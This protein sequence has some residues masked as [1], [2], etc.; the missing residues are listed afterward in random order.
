M[1]RVVKEEPGRGARHY[2][3]VKHKGDRRSNNAKKKWREKTV[4]AAAKITL[5]AGQRLRLLSGLEGLRTK[6]S[7][8]TRCD[9][10][11]A[12]FLGV[13]AQYAP[14]WLFSSR[15]LLLLPE[16]SSPR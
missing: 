3:R 14:I 2:T 11:M 16:E 1:R 9:K 12:F 8:P 6:A 13:A 5:T 15:A 10:L 7:R 4:A